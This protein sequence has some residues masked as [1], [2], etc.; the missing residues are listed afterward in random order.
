MADLHPCAWEIR[1]P[2]P[3][4]GLDDIRYAGVNSVGDYRASV[5]PD[6]TSRAM[7]YH[8]EASAEIERLQAEIDRLSA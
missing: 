6:A 5:H 4:D 3:V 8:D 1:W 2:S 7:V